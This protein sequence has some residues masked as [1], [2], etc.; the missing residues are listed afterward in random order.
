MCMGVWLHVCV[1]LACLGGTQGGQKKSLEPQEL[2]L[3]AAMW[4]LATELVL[5][6][7]SK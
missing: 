4:V 7:S 5:C 1:P 3:L 6:K 2:E